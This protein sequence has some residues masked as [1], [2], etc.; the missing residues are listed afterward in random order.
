MSSNPNAAQA[1]S[2]EFVWQSDMSARGHGSQ[3]RRCRLCCA[4]GKLVVQ[5]I[6]K[7]GGDLSAAPSIRWPAAGGIAIRYDNACT[8]SNWGMRRMA[9]DVNVH[10]QRQS[11]ERL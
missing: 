5:K 10:R 9:T 8:T 4:A 1:C 3:H 7:L 6:A 2:V 11:C